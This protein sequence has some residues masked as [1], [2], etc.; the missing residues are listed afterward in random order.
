[1]QHSVSYAEYPQLCRII[2]S[3]EE[4]SP[5]VYNI[6]SSAELTNSPL[7]EASLEDGLA[8]GQESDFIS[9]SGN[10]NEFLKAAESLFSKSQAHLASGKTTF[11]MIS[12]I[13][14]P[15]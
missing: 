15:T 12:K 8:A 14:W 11:S 9:S 7:T 13:K 3:Y 10:M 6:L 5:A 4:L 1:M 2:L